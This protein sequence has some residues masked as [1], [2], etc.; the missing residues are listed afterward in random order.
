MSIHAISTGV[1]ITHWLV[2]I[3]LSLRVISRRSPV[4]VASAWLAIIFSVPFVGAA[5]YL[6]FGEKRL[7]RGRVARTRAHLPDLQAWQRGLGHAS[8]SSLEGAP[9]AGALASLAKGLY[10]FPPQAGQGIT[11]LDNYPAIFDAIVADIDRAQRRCHLAF[12]IWYGEGRTLDVVEA[13]VRAAQRG[14]QCKAMADALGSKVFLQ[15][16]HLRRLREA[17]VQFEIALPM[18]RIPSLRSRA[19]L[20]NHRKIVVID[21]DIAYTGSQNLVDPRYFKQDS[22]AGQWVDAMARISGPAVSSLDAVFELDWAVE[23]RKPFEAPVVAGTENAEQTGMVLQVVPSGPDLEPEG[24]HQLLLTAI[25]NARSEIVMT[26]PYF[27]PDESF[28]L[29]L[30]AAAQR[31]ARVTLIV[32]AHNDS[33]LVRHASVASFDTLLQAGVDIALFKGGLLHTKSL[34]IDGQTCVFGSVNLDMRS[35]WLNFEISLFVYD[36]EFCARLRALQ[37]TYLDDSEMLTLEQWRRRPR[38]QKFVE[39]TFRLLGPVL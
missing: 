15:G 28:I 17:G 16:P 30:L 24:I 23:T 22:G 13:L 18:G 3:G 9:V 19:D 7:G 34:V 6:L 5:L 31:G 27:V 14:V 35:L 39:D 32:P 36:K 37:N 29:A 21:E 10:G 33:L 20:R 38:W 26:T 11:L 2:V 8:V 25:Y 4:G 12:Y 1:L